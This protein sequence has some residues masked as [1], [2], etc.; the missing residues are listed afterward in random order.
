MPKINR[1]DFLLSVGASSLAACVPLPSQREMTSVASSEITV[2]T[3]IRHNEIRTGFLGLS[4]ESSLL[5]DPLF[6]RADNAALVRLLGNLVPGGVLRIGGTSS[7]L[8][9]WQREPQALPAP[10]RHAV[11]PADIDRLAAFLEATDWKLVYGVNLGHG[12]P[13]RAADEVAYVAGRIG[14]RLDAIQI[15]NEPDLY[16]RHGL[17]AAGYDAEAFVAEW[18]RYAAA[19]RSVAGDVP[20]AGPDVAYKPEWIETFARSCASQVRFLSDHYYP[21]GPASD[22]EVDIRALFRSEGE[23]FQRLRPVMQTAARYFRPARVTEANSCF[24]G[25]KPG[26]SDTMASALWGVTTL[27]DLFHEGWSGVYF[28]GGP[29]S[30]YS[31]IVRAMDGSGYVARPLYYAMLFCMQAMPATLVDATA[32]TNNPGLRVFAAMQSDGPIHVVVVNQDQ[33]HAEDL[34]IDVGRP[35]KKGTALRLF[36]PTLFSQSDIQLAG[37]AIDASGA[38]KWQSLEPAAIEHGVAYVTVSAGTAV[39]LTLD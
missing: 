22:P 16:E 29:Q 26:V 14:D 21:V 18:Q 33:A 3:Q 39:L 24:G 37:G 31:P 28:H 9:L 25:G 1:R 20:L 11:T 27:F 38:W 30:V 34:R 12:D 4:Y 8:A 19:I 13:Q 6:F 23:R 10:F 17:R 15:G 5:A 32:K 2:R 7:D 36:A 35:V